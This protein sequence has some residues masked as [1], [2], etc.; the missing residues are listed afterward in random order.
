MTTPEPDTE[1][2]IIGYYCYEC[3]VKFESDD[4]L[5]HDETMQMLDID[6]V[7]SCPRCRSPEIKIILRPLVETK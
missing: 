4:A 7:Y 5:F 6:K 1:Q 3:A 2:I